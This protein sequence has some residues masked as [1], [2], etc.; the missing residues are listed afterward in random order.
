MLIGVLFIITKRGT[1]PNA[2]QL[3]NGYIKHGI[4]IQWNIIQT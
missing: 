2:H 1:K 4:T 3:M